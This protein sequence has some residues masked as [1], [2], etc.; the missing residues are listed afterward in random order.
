MKWLM[1]L[2]MMLPLFAI[3]Q[4]EDDF[5]APEK[6]REPVSVEDVKQLYRWGPKLGLE[7][8][9]AVSYNH[10][11]MPASIAGGFEKASGGAG[12]DG[13]AGLRVRLYHKIAMAAGFN[14]A[15]RNFSMGYEAVSMDSINP[16]TYKV[17]ESTTLYLMGFYQKTI[18][19]LSRKLHLAQT[20][21]YTWMHRYTGTAVV[22]NLT[23][24]AA[25][26][27]TV[28][29]DAPF[30]YGWSAP[31]GQAE[32]GLEFA[33]K[34]HIANELIIKPY[35]GAGFVFSPAVHTGLVLQTLFGESE[36][37]PSLIN[38]RLG[39]IMETGLWLDGP[40][41]SRRKAMHTNIRGIE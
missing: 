26:G 20:F 13:G 1:L 36:Q 27:G 40:R 30:L 2:C 21:Q 7:V 24:P 39:V 11:Q 18:I 29:L 37:N 22:E 6:A 23:T 38:L 28:D 32:L 9:A 19:E 5:Y 4:E 14:F 35:I 25:G 17:D 10:L 8:H 3:G 12:F 34:I 41:S 15:I 31:T 16:Q 33:Y